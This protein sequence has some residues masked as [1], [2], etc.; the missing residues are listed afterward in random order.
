M[1]VKPSSSSRR[2]RSSVALRRPATATRLTAGFVVIGARA[3]LA[4]ALRGPVARPGDPGL[5]RVVEDE[6]DGAPP[7]RRGS[8]RRTDARRAEYRR[9]GRAPRPPSAA[10]PGP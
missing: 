2:A 7:P 9:G 8:D 5:R 4:Q 3:L 10:R 1:P 6:E